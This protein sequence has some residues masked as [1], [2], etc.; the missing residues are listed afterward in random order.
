[1]L[2]RLCVKN[3]QICI[4]SPFDAIGFMLSMIKYPLTTC[5]TRSISKRFCSSPID[6]LCTLVL[7]LGTAQG[8]SSILCCSL[9][10]DPSKYVGHGRP[11]SG[12]NTS[13]RTQSG[14]SPSEIR[15]AKRRV[16]YYRI[17]PEYDVQLLSV[18]YNED[19]KG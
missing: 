16:Q 10:F 3:T 14:S 17:I 19:Y 13:L 12:C 9:V 2:M 1:L 5:I 4:T 7:D 18:G 11:F 15:F 6:Y 8:R